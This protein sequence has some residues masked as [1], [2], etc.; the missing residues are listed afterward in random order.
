M[1]Q[2]RFP[3]MHAEIQLTRANAAV[4]AIN[5]YGSAQRW[6]EMQAELAVCQDLAKNHRDNAE[7]QLERAKAAFNAISQLRQ[8][9]T[10]ERDAG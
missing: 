4:N 3:I 5:H 7:I 9:A 6:D 1:A 8:G 2:K 10:V